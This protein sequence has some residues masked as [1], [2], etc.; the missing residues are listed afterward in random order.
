MVSDGIIDEFYEEK[1]LESELQNKSSRGN[2]DR[3]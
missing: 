2:S 3:H 1:H